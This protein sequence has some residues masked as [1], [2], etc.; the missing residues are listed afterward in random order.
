MRPGIGQNS[1]T[2][3]CFVQHLGLPF[4]SGKYGSLIIYI[5]RNTHV[6]SMPRAEESGNMQ[7]DI[8]CNYV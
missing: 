7:V 4:F 8:C 2:V 5:T 1:G 6:Q 3:G